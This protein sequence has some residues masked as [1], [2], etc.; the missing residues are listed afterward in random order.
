MTQYAYCDNDDYVQFESTLP[1]GAAPPEVLG[2]TVV[3]ITAPIGTAPFTGARFH[4]PTGQ[5]VDTRSLVDKR[6]AK[7]DGI[8][9]LR[10]AIEFGVFSYG[11]MVFDGDVDAQ[12]R[13]GG[14]ISISKSAIA[15]GQAFS[16]DFTLADNTMV[17][18]TAQDFVAIEL[19]KVQSVA[20]AFAIAVDLRNQIEA[21]LTEQAIEAVAWPE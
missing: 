7:W 5:W 8:K 6:A 11:G 10:D 18:L 13:L 16:A 14:Y 2:L 15:A 17:N 4:V 20:A 21:A 1:T 12:R 19:A 9:Q 3:E